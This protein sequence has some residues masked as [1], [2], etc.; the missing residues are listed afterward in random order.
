MREA[1]RLLNFQIPTEFAPTMANTDWKRVVHEKRL[2]RERAIAEFKA[3]LGPEFMAAPHDID[4]IDILTSKI[5][6]GDLSS[7][8]VTKACIARYL[9][10]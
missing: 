4:D 1:S 3:T 10:S 5:S 8:E 9:L 6:K 2:Q 7:E